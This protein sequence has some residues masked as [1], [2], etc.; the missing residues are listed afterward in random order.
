[1]TSSMWPSVSVCFPA[2]N[3]ESTIRR[4]LE[5][6]DRL[7]SASGLDYEILVC[8][9]GSTDAT[10]PIIEEL[11]AVLPRMR[12]IRHARNRGIFVTFERLYAEATRQFVFLNSADGQWETG[13]L[14]ELLPLAST[15]DIVVASRR[16]RH[17]GR[18]RSMVSWAFNAAPRF[19]FGVTTHDAGAVKLVRRELIRV[20]PLVSTSPFAEAERLIRAAR[21]GYRIID[22][23]VDTVPRRDGRA[24]GAKWPLVVRSAADVARL[25]IALRRERRLMGAR[26]RASGS[27][28]LEG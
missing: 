17:Y 28:G 19:L 24:R 25:W 18:T 11:A 16:H 9:D 22:H 14:F 3:E 21:L 27:N 6:A 10:G 4:V 13:L 5:D 20:L 8:D 15:A 23:P 12:G 7:L 26:A 2:Y 1:M